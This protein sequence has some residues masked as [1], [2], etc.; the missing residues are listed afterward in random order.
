[1]NLTD[2]RYDYP[3]AY[4]GG[5]F[6]VVILGLLA[7][8]LVLPQNAF[9]EALGISDAQRRGH[10]LK[11][12]SYWYS[13]S[14]I[15][16]SSTDLAFEVRYGNVVRFETDAVVASI[17]RGA[18]FLE[19]KLHL[20][21]VVVQ[22]PRQADEIVRAGRFKDARFEVYDR[23]KAVVWIEGKPLN[24]T[25]IELGIATPDPNPPTNI[26]DLAFASYYWTQFKGE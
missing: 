19:E 4:W 7:V 17:P 2:I 13:R 3:K 23:D 9:F 6:S 24:I 21:D 14:V 11:S 10:A 8:F 5:V 15:H 26:V 16:A 18:E 20:A 22:E 12:A 25:L 1:M